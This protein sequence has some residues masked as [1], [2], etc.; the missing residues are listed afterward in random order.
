MLWSAHFVCHIVCKLSCI[1][2]ADLSALF[3]NVVVS[4]RNHGKFCVSNVE[5]RSF[6]YMVILKTTI[7]QTKVKA[8]V[9]TFNVCAAGRLQHNAL[10][11]KK[12][13]KKLKLR[14]KQTMA[15]H[16]SWKLSHLS[17]R[18]AMLKLTHHYTSIAMR[19]HDYDEEMRPDP[20]HFAMCVCVC[21]CAAGVW[22]LCN[23]HALNIIFSAGLW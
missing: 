7:H 23:V 10:A 13:K 2:F 17:S 3:S 14:K 15:Y 20:L 6:G 22:C 1:A 8:K 4:R 12:K 18:N 19:L 5:S 9:V 21:V 11:K 16:I